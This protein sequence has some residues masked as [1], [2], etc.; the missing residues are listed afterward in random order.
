MFGET[1]N[2]HSLVGRG[3]S[4]VFHLQK[5]LISLVPSDNTAGESSTNLLWTLVSNSSSALR[6]TSTTPLRFGWS[7][8]CLWIVFSYVQE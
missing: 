3:F 6:V 7:T 8:P 2:G 5:K 1:F 4:P